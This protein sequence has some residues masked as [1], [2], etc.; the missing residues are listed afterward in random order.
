MFRVGFYSWAVGTLIETG[1][2]L[3]TSLV[4]YPE[5]VFRKFQAPANQF[6]ILH[7]GRVGSKYEG[8]G[9]LIGAN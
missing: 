7:S 5:V 1:R 4:A 3:T 9:L 6:V 8:E 2:Q